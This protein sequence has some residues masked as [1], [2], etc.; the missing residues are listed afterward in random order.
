[1]FLLPIQMQQLHKWLIIL[2]DNT[3][4][5][6]FQLHRNED[7]KK[8][9]LCFSFH[10]QQ[11]VHHLVARKDPLIPF[12]GNSH[13]RQPATFLD[14]LNSLFTR[15]SFLRGVFPKIAAINPSVAVWRE[16]RQGEMVPE[17]SGRRT[18]GRSNYLE[19]SRLRI[20]FLQIGCAPRGREKINYLKN[21]TRQRCTATQKENR[22]NLSD[23]L[24]M[25]CRQWRIRVKK[26]V[27]KGRTEDEWWVSLLVTMKLH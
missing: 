16:W 5:I 22:I 17:F 25:C 26:L 12:N 10:F 15:W 14:G 19:S 4:L 13:S 27:R 11:L 20:S 24:T 21:N 1:M 7:I 18:W 9:A 3:H 8:Q 23:K 2:Q 6:N